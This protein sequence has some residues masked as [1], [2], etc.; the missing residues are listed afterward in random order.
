MSPNAESVDFPSP[1]G[2]VTNETLGRISCTNGNSD[3]SGTRGTISRAMT[4]F[5]RA[6]VPWF[7]VVYASCRKS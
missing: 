7:S 2:T 1:V 5:P 3:D 4:R 6:S